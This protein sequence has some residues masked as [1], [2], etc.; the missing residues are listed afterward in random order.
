ML[1]KD[2]SPMLLPFKAN[3]V[4]DL[5]VLWISHDDRSTKRFECDHFKSLCGVTDK[6]SVPVRSD[7]GVI[8]Y[9]A[10]RYGGDGG[11][12]NGGG[13]RCGN[14]PAGFQLKGIGVN[15]LLGQSAKGR[16][17]T[18][19]LD[20]LDGSIECLYSN[21]LSELLPVGTIRC[22]ALLRLN[23]VSSNSSL[24]GRSDALPAVILV[25]DLAM[26]P[27]HFLRTRGYHPLADFE[28]EIMPD[29]ERVC[30]VM[31]E[32]NQ[33]LGG[34]V[35]FIHYLYKFLHASSKQFSFAKINGICHGAISPSN[36][37][38]DGRWLDLTCAS[39]LPGGKNY[40]VNPSTGFVPF[41][42][43]QNQ[44]KLYA[45]EMIHLFN[46]YNDCSIHHSILNQSYQD[47]LDAYSKHYFWK[48]FLFSSEDI[49]AICESPEGTELFRQALLEL[50]KDKKIIFASP[51]LM[52]KDDA[53]LQF[54]RSTLGL[55][56]RSLNK[57]SNLVNTIFDKIFNKNAEIIKKFKLI[58][59]LRILSKRVVF[60]YLYRQNQIKIIS[61]IIDTDVEGIGSHIDYCGKLVKFSNFEDKNSSVILKN[62]FF[63]IALCEDLRSI[64]LSYDN[65]T[66]Q[67]HSD[68]DVL[69]FHSDSIKFNPFNLSMLI[70][71]HINNIVK[72]G[73]L[74]DVI[75]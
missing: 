30:S 64:E 9:V 55:D 25:R 31:Q 26:R 62:E 8:E 71:E 60:S 24:E 37:S 53:Y 70:L 48:E 1:P 59:Y 14:H 66:L 43:E 11:A 61:S 75:S 10:E 7:G 12:G 47:H 57:N 36:L 72:R 22:R 68:L 29:I 6:I 15:P 45:G 69:D 58:S 17:T 67:I 27:A 40:S 18:G 63:S 5:D 2:F 56:L 46:K 65:Q 21:V 42:N 52:E 38:M 33:R 28:A 50:E 35:E 4:S 34:Q 73:T 44:V 20:L 32:L 16:Y 3:S 19:T 41:F 54:I 74:N 51:E 13:A 49:N 39:F 23:G